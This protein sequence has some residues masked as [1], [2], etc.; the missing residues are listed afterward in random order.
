MISVQTI[1]LSSVGAALLNIAANALIK[2]HEQHKNL[3]LQTKIFI[4]FVDEIILKNLKLNVDQY[5]TLMEDAMIDDKIFESRSITHTPMLNRSI[6]DFFEKRDLIKIFRH[7]EKFSIA[8]I[9]HYFYE[10]EFLKDYSPDKLLADYIDDMN[11]HYDEHKK[12][13]ENF[14]E[15]MDWCKNASNA[16]EHFKNHLKLQKTHTEELYVQFQNVKNNLMSIE[17]LQNDEV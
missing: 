6:L 12:G 3:K 1:L 7:S 11:T 4:E 10:I 15:H 5:N 17:I 14:L 16:K 9:Y 13:N 8:N 2:R